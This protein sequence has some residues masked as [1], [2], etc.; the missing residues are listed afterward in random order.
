MIQHYL[1]FAFRNLWKYRT[2][3]V[4]S[5]VGLAVGFACF[6]LA[7]LWI[8]Y[9]RTYDRQLKGI[10]RTYVLYS[11]NPQN[12][13]GGQPYTES[14]ALAATTL[15][16]EYPEVE[17]ACS[18]RNDPSSIRTETGVELTTSLL[19]TDS[20]FLSIDPD[21]GRL[22]QGSMDFLQ[23][24]GKVALTEE[25][26]IRL[27]GSADNAM[28]QKITVDGRDTLT[29]RAIL[30]NSVSH[31]NLYF[32]GWRRLRD[33]QPQWDDIEVNTLVRL[34]PDTDVPTLLR[35]MLTYSVRAEVTAWPLSGEKPVTRMEEMKPFEFSHLMPLSQYH[36][37]ELNR[38][39]PIR[40]LYLY[41]FSITGILVIACALLNYLSLFVMRMRTRM[42]EV[43]LRRV[44]G[45]STVGLFRLFSIEYLLSLLISGLLGLAII[46]VALPQFRKLSQVEGSI[47][48]ETLLYFVGVLLLSLLC[49][50]PFV[51]RRHRQAFKGRS[52]WG[53]GKWSL[54]LQI[55]IC[56]LFIFC[57][58]VMQKQL[59][60]LS[61]GDLGWD[62]HN[63]AVINLVT[64]TPGAGAI[65][66]KRVDEMPFVTE[67]L[68]G[69]SPLFPPS[70]I[71]YVSYEKW[72]GKPAGDT[73]KVTFDIITGFSY[74][75][76]YHLKLLE[77]S[78]P[79]KN[80]TNKVLL[81]EAAVPGHGHDKSRGEED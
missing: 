51:L 70:T 29:V 80:D 64:N 35:K 47:Y 67:V 72:D 62:R 5:I 19:M 18:Y 11:T 46:E 55:F 79:R 12:A 40:I 9:E 23:L 39:L 43:E 36:Y 73:K 49:L 27:F 1:K 21:A 32:G 25:T 77:G 74:I 53:G 68:K 4:I 60:F 15:R 34:Q 33:R 65:F 56:L 78:V 61:S 54:W 31:S 16:N 37:S 8:H 28:G 71:F 44:C 30:R 13:F 2:Q 24:K 58:S 69:V 41:L 17:T 38:Q 52:R 50:A 10:D 26:A 22:L 66:S 7:N 3:S 76:F 20:T 63:T 48:G 75:P 42:R 45:S 6:A 59:H 81:N 14:S 57:I